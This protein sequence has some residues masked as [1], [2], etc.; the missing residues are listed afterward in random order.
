MTNS[1]GRVFADVR[2]R[3]PAT[4]LRCPPSAVARCYCLVV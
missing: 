4:P 1:D 2:R 3:R